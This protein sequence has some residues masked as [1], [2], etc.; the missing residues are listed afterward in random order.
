MCHTLT[1][2]YVV[3]STGRDMFLKDMNDDIIVNDKDQKQLA[4][5]SEPGIADCLDNIFREA[6]RTNSISL[7]VK[8]AA[9]DLVWG[10]L[11]EDPGSRPSMEEVLNHPF[12]DWAAGGLPLA[13]NLKFL[14]L[15]GRHL[16]LA[17]PA[18]PTTYVQDAV[19]NSK[20]PALLTA[21]QL[22]DA[23][24][25]DTLLQRGAPA[26]AVNGTG[27]SALHLMWLWEPSSVQ[28]RANL[29]SEFNAVQ[30]QERI[31]WAL[32]CAG[33]S[34]SALNNMQLTPIQMA[35]QLPHAQRMGEA[36]RVA[37]LLSYTGKQDH[38]WCEVWA[39]WYQESWCTALGITPRSES[40]IGSFPQSGFQCS[41]DGAV[42]AQDIHLQFKAARH[43]A[44]DRLADVMQSCKATGSLFEDDEFQVDEENGAGVLYMVPDD[45]P[46][47]DIMGAPDKWARP[48]EIYVANTD[49][50]LAVQPQI[51][52]NIVQGELGTVTENGMAVISTKL[53]IMA[54]TRD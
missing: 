6:Y 20:Q 7:A 2:A 3:D 28:Q 49:V 10:C 27:N 14:D 22:L 38:A 4:E 24:A 44:Q 25:V 42:V 11:Q 15:E 48:H 19:K 30:R 1:I 32:L 52:C 16:C 37:P 5:W 18:F 17:M 31:L 21:A 40:V 41:G 46:N 33:A 47:A 51:P 12:F 50:Q 45:P 35:L 36:L 26:S 23:D 9:Q 43:E 13:S 39:R 54:C 34:F 29:A 53:A 8:L